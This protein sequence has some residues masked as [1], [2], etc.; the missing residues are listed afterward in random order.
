VTGCKKIYQTNSP[1]KQP[2]VA[3]LISDK[4]DFKLKLVRRDKR[5][6]FILIKGAIYQEEITINLHVPNIG[7]PNL[8]KH[9]L[10]N[11]STQIDPNTLVVRDFN[12]P[13]SLIDRSSKKTNKKST[14]KLWD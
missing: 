10:L 2:G 8:I 3:T 1:P 4:V 7:A 13:Q 14:E 11:L 6:H 9:A 12:I 5:G